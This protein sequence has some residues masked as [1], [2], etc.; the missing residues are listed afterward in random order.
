LIISLS[1]TFFIDNVATIDL[2][3]VL[4]PFRNLPTLLSSDF[5]KI[6]VSRRNEQ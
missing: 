2:T 6:K 1:G 4:S 3:R 5:W